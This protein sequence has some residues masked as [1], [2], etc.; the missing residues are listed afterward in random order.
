MKKLITVT[1]TDEEYNF[2]RWLADKKDITVP[3]LM[4]N[5]FFIQFNWYKS[6]YWEEFKNDR[7]YTSD[8]PIG[9]KICRIRQ[10]KGMTQ[11]NLAEKVGVITQQ[12]SEW[13]NGRRTPK[14]S[15]IKK[16]ASALDISVSDLI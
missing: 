5:A 11:A 7:T 13:E 9:Q 8:E 15:N 1:F 6:K 4:Y 12:I 3:D 10:S 14:T 16:L 2:V